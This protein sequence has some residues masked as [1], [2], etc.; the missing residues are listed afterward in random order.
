M[1][2]VE[3]TSIEVSGGDDEVEDVEVRVMKTQESRKE[4]HDPIRNIIPE[5]TTPPDTRAARRRGPCTPSLRPPPRRGR[6]G[7]RKDGGGCS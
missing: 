4:S 1:K 2:G 3:R 5:A 6:E 7:G